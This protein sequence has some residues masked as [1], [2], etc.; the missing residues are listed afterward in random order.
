MALV[1]CLGVFMPFVEAD[2]TPS[3][4]ILLSEIVQVAR[5]RQGAESDE[6]EQEIEE[7]LK[8]IVSA[9]QYCVC[10][11]AEG[12]AINSQAV[13]LHSKFELFAAL[14][15]Y[16]AAER[17]Y[18]Q[19]TLWSWA[20]RERRFELLQN[21]GV[22]FLYLGWLE[23]ADAVLSEVVAQWRLLGNDKG[24]LETQMQRARLKRL[25]GRHG[26][27]REAIDEALEVMGSEDRGK[28]IWGSTHQEAARQHMRTGELD[29]AAEHLEQA[30]AEVGKNSW[31]Y[32]YLLMDQ[33][34]LLQRQGRWSESAG[35]LQD[36]LSRPEVL[37][38]VFTGAYLFHLASQQAAAEG[39]PHD[40][41][42]AADQG[43][44]L[45][46]QI[47]ESRH[48]AAAELV[49]LRRK[50]QWH[51][52]E[53]AAQIEGPAGVL[54]I[55]ER[56]KAYG[57]RVSLWRRALDLRSQPDACSPPDLAWRLDQ[58]SHGAFELE[59]HGRVDLLRCTRMLLAAEAKSSKPDAPW[60]P[61]D[62]A[63][64]GTQLGDTPALVLAMGSHD[65]YVLWWSDGELEGSWVELS[66]GRLAELTDLDVLGQ[67]GPA[68]HAA[69][70]E[71]GHRIL[72]PVSAELDRSDTLWVVADGPLD[73][74]PLDR[75]IRPDT[76]EPLFM[77]HAVAHLPSLTT[78]SSI[79]A[80]A[81]SDALPSI[82]V[83]GDPVF[84]DRDDRW[85]AG[86]EPSRGA[87]EAMSTDR[88]PFSGE[89]A[90]SI[91]E[92]YRP[93]RAVTV[94]TG[95]DA[96]R[97]RLIHEAGRHRVLHLAT[98]ADSHLDIPE[99][100]RIRL[101][102]L[103]TDG[104]TVPRCDLYL[105]EISNLDLEGNLVVLSMC[106]SHVG[107]H[108]AG[109]GPLGL[110]RAF[111]AAG[112]SVVVASLWDV[113]DRQTASFMVEFHRGLS[114]GRT[115]AQALRDAKIMA[116]SVDPDG[117]WAAF[118]AYGDGEWRLRA[119]AP[120]ENF[121]KKLALSAQPFLGDGVPWIETDD[122]HSIHSLTS[123]EG[124]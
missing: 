27:A 36:L 87:G 118:V 32:G 68:A 107:R 76:G 70:Q 1:L 26:E 78:L 66:H 19:G 94:L 101:S 121:S 81:R 3:C 53:L 58:A 61:V 80:R 111:L 92:L 15:V 114:R 41:V 12:M 22:S 21:R 72:E 47:W 113:S 43:L 2:L 102:C 51:R 85:P 48:E 105:N 55:F 49:A 75:L 110:S 33:V 86:V 96:G 6:K 57:L 119:T 67:G 109:E 69:L 124:P 112:A 115:V 30:F 82:L 122:K 100:S 77:S 18:G 62:R 9:S 83:L 40:A 42:T 117:D 31:R 79:R 25:Q 39:R 4:R 95:A 13:M 99:R 8:S 84:S 29:R 73:G 97:E 54:E 65:P 106:E 11:E 17:A 5:E 108:R 34:E 104:K 60:T 35:L 63:A 123:E 116:R 23:H 56:Y 46:D 64:L 52:L 37:G 16:Q 74:F 89:E 28:T 71:L 90:S 14:D 24:L 7:A 93:D 10:H 120:Q 59:S 38:K 103:S 20:H 44:D 45:L 88:L 98:H 50:N 91:A